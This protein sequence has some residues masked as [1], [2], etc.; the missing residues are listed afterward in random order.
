MLNVG[1]G[2][3]QVGTKD[4]PLFVAKRSKVRNADR[5]L[6]RTGKEQIAERNHCF[7]SKS[8]QLANGG[9]SIAADPFLDRFIEIAER[10]ART[11]NRPAK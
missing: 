1:D 10:Q 3:A 8:L 6:R 11:V 2:V 4:S 9:L 7:A 5:F